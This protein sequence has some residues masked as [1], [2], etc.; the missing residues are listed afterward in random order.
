MC[1][2]VGF[3]F[4]GE[5]SSAK[6]VTCDREVQQPTISLQCGGGSFFLLLLV[7]GLVTRLS[8]ALVV[9]VVVLFTSAKDPYSFCKS[10]NGS[11]A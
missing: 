7:N 1:V 10:H 2:C 4:R 5:N 3:F 11:D 8:A 6:L 9:Q